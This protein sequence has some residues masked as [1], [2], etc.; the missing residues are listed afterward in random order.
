MVEEGTLTSSDLEIV[1][2]TS[3]PEEAAAT[4]IAC[5]RRQCRHVTN[6]ADG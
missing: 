4:V 2:Y 3:D 5:Y 1:S 6:G